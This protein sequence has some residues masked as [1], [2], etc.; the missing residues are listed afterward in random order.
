MTQGLEALLS[1]MGIDPFYNLL[2]TDSVFSKVPP[3]ES[4]ITL[5][6]KSVLMNNFC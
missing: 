2:T 4:F 3:Q 6:I 1:R 5:F